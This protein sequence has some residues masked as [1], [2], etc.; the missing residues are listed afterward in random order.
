MY[1]K[2]LKQAKTR[3]LNFRHA[4]LTATRK[5]F[6]CMC[7]SLFAF[8]SLSLQSVFTQVF[9]IFSFLAKNTTK[10]DY[11]EGRLI[12]LANQATTKS[13]PGRGIMK[14]QHHP[15]AK[16]SAKISLGDSPI[17][18]T[19]NAAIEKKERPSFQLSGDSRRETTLGDM[20]AAAKSVFSSLLRE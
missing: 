12:I 16:S 2:R 4:A 5:V 7:V 14:G 1:Q 17:S 11:Q 15:R 13:R 3:G 10:K 9:R 6:G 8:P 19:T 20:A 18:A